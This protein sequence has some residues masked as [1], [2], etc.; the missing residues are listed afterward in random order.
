MRSQDVLR[1][2]VL[3]DNWSDESSCN[4]IHSLVSEACGIETNR[5]TDRNLEEIG[6]VHRRGSGR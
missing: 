5:Q 1:V 2:E 4:E 3:I 6:L